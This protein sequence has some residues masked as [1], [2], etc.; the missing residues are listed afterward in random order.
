M[1]QVI[2]C[3]PNSLERIRQ[4]VQIMCITRFKDITPREIDVLCEYFQSE[5]TEDIINSFKLNT[6][7]SSTNF[8][9]TSKRLAEKGILIPIKNKDIGKD[10][11]PDLKVLKELYINN[12]NKYLIIQVNGVE[13][14]V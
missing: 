6:G 2:K 9:Q 13:E 3:K 7:T 1:Q 12:D 5:T 11:H 14:E 8:Y 4:L 10:L